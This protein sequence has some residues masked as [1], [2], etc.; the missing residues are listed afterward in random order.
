MV[1]DGSLSMLLFALLRVGWDQL[2]RGQLLPRAQVR[3]CCNSGLTPSL[4]EHGDLTTSSVRKV[5]SRPL[6]RWPLF[7]GPAMP[8]V[9]AEGPQLVRTEHP[10][11]SPSAKLRGSVGPLDRS[12]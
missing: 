10:T 1:A 12:E 2:P 4:H 8:C 7:S 6:H 11:G 3:A 9:R 5:P